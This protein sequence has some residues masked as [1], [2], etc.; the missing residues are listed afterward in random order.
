MVDGDV[1]LADRAGLR[2]IS[3]YG[4]VRQRRR[5]GRQQSVT[6]DD[7]NGS[8]YSRRYPTIILLVD[9]CHAGC[10]AAGR[11]RTQRRRRHRKIKVE[12]H[13]YSKQRRNS[14]RTCTGGSDQRSDNSLASCNR[15]LRRDFRRIAVIQ[16]RHKSDRNHLVGKRL[17]VLSPHRS[18]RTTVTRKYDGT[19]AEHGHLKRRCL[20][21]NMFDAAASKPEA[22]KQVARRRRE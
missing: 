14:E 2:R 11:R 17:R 9:A 21:S 22:W 10:D 8:S 16:R 13:F 3:S 7:S 6:P 15:W 20:P 12:K 5:G 19:T 18:C 4:D 1:L